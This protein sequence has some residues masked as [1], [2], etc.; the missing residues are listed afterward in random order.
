LAPKA[1]TANSRRRASE[2]DRFPFCIL[3]EEATVVGG[4]RHDGDET[5]VLRGGAHHRG[6]A[7]VDLFDGFCARNAWTRDGRLEG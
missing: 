4:I 1:L 2:I 5:V 3:V 7:D 6:S